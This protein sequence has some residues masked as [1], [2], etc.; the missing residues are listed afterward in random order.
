MCVC[1]CVQEH[2]MTVLGPSRLVRPIVRCE[3]QT[4]SR[5]SYCAKCLQKVMMPTHCA[6]HT[7]LLLL[8]AMHF[9]PFTTLNEL[10]EFDKHNLYN[11]VQYSSFS[12]SLT[13]PLPT[14]AITFSRNNSFVC[15][16]LLLL[17]LLLFA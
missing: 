15:F 4:S 8:L 13:A 6:A 17:L 1:V 7:S 12:S 11:K 5:G 9:N 16:L 10:C 14:I 2:D 3:S